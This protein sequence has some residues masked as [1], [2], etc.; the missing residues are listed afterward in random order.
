MNTDGGALTSVRN[1]VLSD[2]QLKAELP[3]RAQLRSAKPQVTC[4]SLYA[5]ESF[6]V[7]CY[8]AIAD[9]YIIVSSKHVRTAQLSTIS[10]ERVDSSSKTYGNLVDIILKIPS[11]SILGVSGSKS[12]L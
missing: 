11:V 12:L 8:S 2:L 6:V 5:T 7:I 9:P 3:H 4:S 10:D 1:Q